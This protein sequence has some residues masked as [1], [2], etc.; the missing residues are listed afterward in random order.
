MKSELHHLHVNFLAVI[1]IDFTEESTRAIREQRDEG[2]V[3]AARVATGSQI[4]HQ[5]LHTPFLLTRPDW[6]T[7]YWTGPD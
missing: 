4:L 6:Q 5:F 2:H 1:K 3:A 7:T